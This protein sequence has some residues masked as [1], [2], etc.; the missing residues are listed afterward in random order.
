MNNDYIAA[1]IPKLTVNAA[2]TLKHR[3]PQSGN[4]LLGHVHTGLGKWTTLAAIGVFNNLRAAGCAE[5]EVRGHGCGATWNITP[6]GEEVAA[7][8]RNQWGEVGHLL[9]KPA[10]R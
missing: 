4:S 3:K 6:L 10:R 5:E 8:L 9:R 1:L 2:I 7:Y